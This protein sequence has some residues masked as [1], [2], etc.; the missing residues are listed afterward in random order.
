[1]KSI[2]IG[3]IVGRKSYGKDIIFRVKNI[4]NTKKDSIAILT[5]VTKRVEA[6]SRLDDLELIEKDRVKKE[7]EE[8][9]KEI[10]ERVRSTKSVNVNENY[11]IGRGHDCDIRLNDIS[12]SRVHSLIHLNN[13]V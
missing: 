6:D 9:N 7:I 11:I 1:M 5:G 2:K 3:D 8:I 10:K 13:W 12:V 4:I